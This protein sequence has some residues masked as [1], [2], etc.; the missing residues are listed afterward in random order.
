MLDSDVTF[1]VRRYDKVVCWFDQNWPEGAIW[2]EG[3]VRP[4]LDEKV[5]EA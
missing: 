4:S 3:V 5:T 1:T 2:P